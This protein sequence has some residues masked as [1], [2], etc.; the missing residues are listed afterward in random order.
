MLL[1]AGYD[2]TTST[3]SWILRDLA[4]HPVE[5]DKLRTAL[6][7]EEATEARINCLKLDCVIKESMRLNPVAPLASGRVVPKMREEEEKD[8]IV[9]KGG[10]FIYCP[11]INCRNKDIYEDPDIQA[12]PLG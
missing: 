3:L 9:P 6:R 11:Y 4:M 5:Q 8:L 12:I 10:A 7:K 2:T 1:F